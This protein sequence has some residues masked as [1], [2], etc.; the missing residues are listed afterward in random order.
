VAKGLEVDWVVIRVNTVRRG[1]IVAG[2]AIMAAA[3]IAFAYTRI[4]PPPNVEARRAVERAQAAQERVAESPQ[5]ERL[6]Q[7]IAEATSKLEDA[8]TAL[9][10]EQWEQATQLAQA[11]R[12]MFESI[13]GVDKR[14]V[15]GAGQIHSFKGQVEVERA[16]ASGFVEATQG[17]KVF[18]GDFI[19]TGRNGTA[20]ILFNDG[21]LYRISP[22]S[23]L[24]IHQP[25]TRV[26]S[27]EGGTVK[28]VNGTINVYTSSS[29]ST[30][31]TD[32]TE[33]RVD[34]DSRVAVDV[35]TGE[36]TRVSTYSGKATVKN[37]KGQQMIITS[38]EEVVATA[39]GDFSPKKA[40][41]APPVPLEPINREFDMTRHPIIELKWKVTDAESVYLQVSR[42]KRFYPDQLD[43]DAMTPRLNGARLQAMAPGTYF[44]RVATGSPERRISEWSAAERF[45]I[46]A[47]GRRHALEDQIPPRLENV[48][49]QQHGN[50]II[51]DGITEVGASVTINSEPVGVGSDGYFSKTIELTQE[52]RNQIVVIATDSAG[53]RS[54]STHTVF[55]EF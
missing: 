31:K 17:M 50:V 32:T 18:N 19:Q 45:Q 23:L 3:L 16:G 12:T 6:A 37:P 26:G 5:P 36:E 21:S 8:H 42:T 44:W 29:A 55:V 22:N 13:L 15:A 20:E 34:G 24:E 4:N 49:V 2:T 47:P 25:A 40:I 51:I 14:G 33:T 38:R 1:I 41:P 52:G 28:M 46:L 39:T 35:G 11:S 9:A 30:V 43:V 10:A 48:Q 7:E 54:D 53:N 27:S